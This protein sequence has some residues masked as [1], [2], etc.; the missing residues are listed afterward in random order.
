MSRSSGS[1]RICWNGSC[2][3]VSI[4]CITALHKEALATQ[5][6]VVFSHPRWDFGSP[7]PRIMPRLANKYRVTCGGP[8][9]DAGPP[10]GRSRALRRNVWVCRPHSP[11]AA[12]GFHDDQ[13]HIL[14][15]LLAGLT[16]TQLTR[17]YRST[18]WL[19][20]PMALPLVGPNCSPGCSFTI[21][22]TNSPHSTMR[23]AR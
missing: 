2:C 16:K 8:V 19:H 22:R 14:T 11:V 1:S 20:P 6:L 7:P 18:V 9:V 23:L 12:A 15:V 4:V 13:I 10:V 3:S 5:S 21:A 17:A